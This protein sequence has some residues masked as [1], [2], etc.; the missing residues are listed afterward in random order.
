MKRFLLLAIACLGAFV[1]TAC[2]QDAPKSAGTIVSPESEPPSVLGTSGTQPDGI[3]FVR[4]MMNVNG[5]MK[6]FVFQDKDKDGFKESL[7][8]SVTPG[9]KCGGSPCSKYEI[10][11]IRR[12]ESEEQKPWQVQ[13]EKL[14]SLMLRVSSATTK[15]SF[16]RVGISN[17]ELRMLLREF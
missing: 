1:V 12:D 16:A 8:V 15:A 5:A 2:A 4:V 17:E 9:D 13:L 11:M 10:T 7:T 14:R 6:M 3:P